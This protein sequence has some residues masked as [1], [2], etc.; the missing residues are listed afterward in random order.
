MV[1]VVIALACACA[2]RRIPA[3]SRGQ[4]TIVLLPDPDSGALGSATVSNTGG[5]VA[6]SAAREATT[7]SANRPPAPARILTDSEV[8]TVFG[9]VLSAQPPPPL[10]FIVYFRFE[11]DDLADE[12]RQ[13]IPDVLRQ[14]AARSFPEVTV[15]GHTDT[16]GDRAANF[17][18]GLDRAMRVRS[19]LVAAGLDASL[20]ELISHGETD[21]L[22]PTPDDTLEPRNRRVEIAVR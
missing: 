19:L 10:H 13:L 18:L 8:E 3:P 17:Q 1:L 5:T 21:L 12:S 14:I 16:T 22:V 6:L 11:S 4:A 2:Q 7:A 20:I 9:G 15:V